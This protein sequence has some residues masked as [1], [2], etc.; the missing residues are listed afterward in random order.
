M[1]TKVIKVR[2]LRRVSGD[3]QDS[4]MQ[5]HEM[6]KF[7][8]KMSTENEKWIIEHTYDEDAVS[9]FKN[10]I[11]DREV[12][13]QVLRD[14]EAKKFDLFLAYKFD[15]IGRKGINTQNWIYKMNQILKIPV[16]STDEGLLATE[17]MV[18][19]IKL[20][21]YAGK[22][23]QESVDTSK[24]TND[25]H[26]LMVEKCIFRGGYAP[27]GYKLVRSGELG[28]PIYNKK[29]KELFVLT[30][31]ETE[32]QIIKLIFDL[33]YYYGY[34][35]N[36]ITKHLNK[37][38]ILSRSNKPWSSGT[39]RYILR[40][41]IY[42]GV[43][44]YGKTKSV[45]GTKEKHRQP[46]ENWISSQNPN[47]LWIIVEPDKFDKVQEIIDSNYNK[48]NL[49][50]PYEKNIRIPTKSKILF[51]GFVYCGYCGSAMS[52]T[53][54]KSSSKKRTYYRCTGKAFNKTNCEGQTTYLKERIEETVLL[55][56]YEYVANLK[57][58]DYSKEI[59]K[60]NKKKISKI[61]KE[62]ENNLSQLKES[63][64]ELDALNNEIS[65]VLLGKSLFNQEQLSTAI[66]NKQNEV[67]E[68]INRV[69]VLENDFK[70]YK[71]T[72]QDLKHLQ[73]TIP[74]W[75][76]EFKNATFE[77]QKMLLAMIID[78]VFIY[79]DKVEVN[80]KVNL[81]DMLS[82]VHNREHDLAYLTTIG[83]FE[84][85]ITGALV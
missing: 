38:Q 40:N 18:D 24:R 78:K 19:Q 60:Y 45:L 65:K 80:I 34:G 4:E 31:D 58:I 62:Y 83:C 36:R 39:I 68:L 2:C 77:R 22:A 84:K 20:S 3:K 25:N 13:N 69:S 63:E 85:I 48:Y 29:G 41:P 33:A 27:Y 76:T 37:E 5:M 57:E 6:E 64:R 17:T 42:K 61:E 73:Q 21:I 1:A 82:N 72:I 35:S 28:S 30:I 54:N 43:Y 12:M 79:K 51:G 53:S 26:K 49:G 47:E 55:Q 44:T 11:E 7:C 66:I 32:S 15:R 70:N 10:L 8:E 52:V 81:K 46:K 56:I 75:L 23:Q 14:A 16:W 50:S 9:G 71:L 59:E 67:S 74:N